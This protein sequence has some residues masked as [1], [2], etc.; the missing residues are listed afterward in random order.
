MSK[1]DSLLGSIFKGAIDLT[2]TTVKVAYD[3]SEEIVKK[4]YEVATSKEAKKLYKSTGNYVSELLSFKPPS[5][6]NLTKQKLVNYLTIEDEHIKDTYNSISKKYKKI[7]KH[8]VKYDLFEIHWRSISTQMVFG[9]LAK[10]QDPVTYTE[11]KDY[12]I[13]E[14]LETEPEIIRLQKYLYS[15]AYT[16]GGSEISRIFNKECFNNKLPEEAI[17]E[18]DRGFAFIHDAMVHGLN[19]KLK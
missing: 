1:K 7:K 13:L 17:D 18:L 19:V 15:K 10:T 8:I 3:V 2:A 14:I 12:L 6:E 16:N 5:T 11:I 4:G 9:A